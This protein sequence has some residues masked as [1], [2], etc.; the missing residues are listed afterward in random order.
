MYNARSSQSE[1]RQLATEL[2]ALASPL[3][4]MPARVGHRLGD[5]QHARQDS[6]D[7]PALHPDTVSLRPSMWVSRLPTE[8]S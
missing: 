8:G 2:Y 3:P 6:T 7:R 1:V 5:D 4:R